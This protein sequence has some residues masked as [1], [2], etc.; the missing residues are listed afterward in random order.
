MEK[1]V[2]IIQTSPKHFPG[3]PNDTPKISLQS[4]QKQKKSQNFQICKNKAKVPKTLPK[5]SEWD[6]E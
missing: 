4:E 2:K 6:P 1:S 3:L 5:P